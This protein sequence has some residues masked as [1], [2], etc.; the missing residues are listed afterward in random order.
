MFGH[1]EVVGQKFFRDSPEAVAGKLLVT[2]IFH[3]IQGEGPFAGCPAVFIRLAKCQLQCSF[4]DTYFDSGDWMYLGELFMR[5]RDACKEGPIPKLLII[6]GGEPTLQNPMLN[7][8][9]LWM[10]DGWAPPF[11]SLQIE[12]NGLILPQLPPLVTVVT[13]PKCVNGRYPKLSP[14]VLARTNCLK[15]VISGDRQSPYYIIPGW[16]LEWREATGREIFISPMA[17]YQHTPERTRAIY[18]S[19]RDPTISEREAAERVSFWEPDLLDIGKC[20]RNYEWA[21]AYVLR[22]NLRLSIQ[23]HLFASLP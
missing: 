17:E 9:A 12:T 10:A 4:C 13:S 3:T 14:D 19:R 15:F 1:N 23:Q 18:E 6:T 21:A 11:T 7:R 22:H 8:V 16:A 20:Q 2:S 5:A